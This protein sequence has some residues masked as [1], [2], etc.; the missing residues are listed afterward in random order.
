MGH[1]ASSAVSLGASV[2]AALLMAGCAQWDDGS[3]GRSAAAP[4]CGKP[5]LHA[6]VVSMS[7]APGRWIT[8]AELEAS[9]PR[10]GITVGFDI[11]DTLIFPS[12]GF[13]VVLNNTDAPGGKSLYGASQ[14]EVVANPKSWEDLHTTLDR[15]ALPKAA[16]RQ[17]VEMHKRRG[18]R[19]VLIT[20]RSGVNG[21]ALDARMRRW[22]GVDFAEPVVFTAF[23]PKTEAI[24]SRGIAVYYGDSDSD[25]EYAQAAGARGVRVLRA[26]NAIAYDKLPCFGRFGEDVIVDSDH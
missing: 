7:V 8:L 6:G 23:K 17:L 15:Y 20:A 26:A 24:R 21:A 19:I 11:D 10:A 14:K 5:T 4:A 25:I 2:A 18:D 12:P 3:K 1:R 16:G 13:E 22:F 9:L